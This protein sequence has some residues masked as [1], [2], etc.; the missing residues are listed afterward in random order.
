MPIF[1]S[2]PTDRREEMLRRTASALLVTALGAGIL[3][4]SPVAAADRKPPKIVRAT[5]VDADEDGLADRVV[6][7]YSERIKHKADRDGRYP[8]TIEG[9]KIRKVQ[10]AKGKRLVVVLKE[11]AGPEKPVIS[12]QRSRRQPV[13][14]RAGNQA[15][16]QKFLKVIPFAP[17]LEPGSSMLV[18]TPEGPGQIASDDGLVACPAEC[19]VVYD[20]GS[21]VGLTAVLD[22]GAV[23]VGWGGS[24][25][26]TVPVC[27][28]T[29]DDNLETATAN[30]AWPVT[31]SVGGAGSVGS[32][33]G[34]VQCPGSC[35]GVFEEGTRVVL[36]ASPGEGS[37]FGGW[38]GECSG[39]E[40]TCSFSVTG[41]VVVGASFEGDDGGTPVPLPTDA[42][43][44]LPT[45][46]LVPPLL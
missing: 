17:E 16:Q 43:V 30:F 29:L 40:T 25:A 33:D 42:P 2:L 7:L 38:T 32:D 3:Q 46:T 9:F 11:A 31:V 44:P 8:F 26:G 24:C 27:S 10:A 15:A 28:L 34:Q 21:T 1:A 19:S 35:T 20:T 45:I 23:F 22:P 14:D 37:S 36:T 6:L 39:A 13:K 4:A 18:A 12:Y 41:P 5:M